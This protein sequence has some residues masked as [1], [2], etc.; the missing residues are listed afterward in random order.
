M[1]EF[2]R[3]RVREPQ[4]EGTGLCIA[5]PRWPPVMKSRRLEP[6]LSTSSP[7]GAIVSFP[8]RALPGG[9]TISQASGLLSG[10]SFAKAEGWVL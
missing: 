3:P 8:V 9:A 4:G 5:C 7:G 1:G 6:R 10:Q 2:E